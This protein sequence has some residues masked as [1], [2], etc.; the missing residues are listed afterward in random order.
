MIAFA[1]HVI[2]GFGLESFHLPLFYR[3]GMFQLYICIYLLYAT[4][5]IFVFYCGFVLDKMSGFL[6]IIKVN[7]CD[8]N[9]VSLQGTFRENSTLVI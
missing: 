4:N 3:N 1:S 2:C 8:F 6:V 9:A 7:A 5:E